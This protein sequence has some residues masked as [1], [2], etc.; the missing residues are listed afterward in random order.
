MEFSKIFKEC[1]RQERK[2][3]ENKYKNNKMVDP[4]PTILIRDKPDNLLL[5]IIFKLFPVHEF[6]LFLKD[7]YLKY[8]F[9][10]SFENLSLPSYI[11][12]K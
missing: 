3:R 9:V 11:K 6:C 8:F 1:L 12:L 7:K 5:F 2:N 10:K 4:N